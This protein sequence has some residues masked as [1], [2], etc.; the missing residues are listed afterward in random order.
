MKSEIRN[1]SPGS[2][3]RLHNL[4]GLMAIVA[5]LGALG[6]NRTAGPP[7]PLP[8]EH[9]PV[10][11]KKAFATASPEVKDLVAEIE[12]A[13]TSKD[14]PAAYQR[15]QMICNLPEATQE[16]RQVSARA[17]LALTTLLQAAQAQGD[18]GAAAVL[19]QHQRTR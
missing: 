15:V 12:R 6:C 8:V 3:A 7:A 2:F 11:M 18:Q 5:I 13:L 14:Y 19:K 4:P 10:E 16:Q 9:I 1:P 17:L